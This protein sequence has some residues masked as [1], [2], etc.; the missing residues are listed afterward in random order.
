MTAS[1]I[2]G[3]LAAGLLVF[4]APAHAKAPKV[5]ADQQLEAVTA[6]GVSTRELAVDAFSWPRAAQLGRLGGSWLPPKPLVSLQW[7][8]LGASPLVRGS[9]PRDRVVFN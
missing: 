4:A 8:G 9:F 1:L 6:G 5:L 2:A 7:R 3:Y